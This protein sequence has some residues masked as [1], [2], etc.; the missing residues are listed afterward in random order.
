M[1]VWNVYK[2]QQLLATWK[3]CIYSCDAFDA[4]S[5]SSE[6]TV[7]EHDVWRLPCKSSFE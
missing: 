3:E 1:C 4:C 2:H 6:L 5:C 7:E